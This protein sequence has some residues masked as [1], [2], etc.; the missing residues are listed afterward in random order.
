MLSYTGF[1]EVYDALMDNV[2]YEEW[3]AY[4][5]NLLEEQGVTEGTI[6]D[7]ACGTGRITQGLHDVGFS[8]IGVDNSVEMLNIAVR[9]K[10]EREILYI[11]QDMRELRLHG[12]I[13]AFVCICDGMNYILSLE[14]MRQV[15]WGVAN[16]LEEGG[17]FIFDLNTIYKYKELLGETTI[18]ENREDMSFIWEN[19]YDEEERVNEYDLTIYVKNQNEP[20]FS[21]FEEL[22]YQKGYEIH[23]IEMTLKEAGLKIL[24][25]FDAFT[26]DAVHEE[27]ERIYFIAKKI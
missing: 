2:P 3:I 19:Y 4:L 20:S 7:L 10:G 17:I 24:D 18:A 6:C 14:E 15:F 11:H 26:K 12:K 25:V 5:L 23:E 9:K 21:R 22:H 16:H 27:S 13:Q 8:M 1:A